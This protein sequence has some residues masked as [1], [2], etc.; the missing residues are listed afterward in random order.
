MLAPE[1]PLTFDLELAKEQTNENPVYYVQYGHARIASVFKNADASEIE[2]ARSAHLNRLTD[3]TEI[4][5]IRRLA[6]MPNIVQNV[7]ADL[8][9]HR[10]TRYARDIAGDFHQFYHACRILTEDRDERLARLA[11]CIATKTVLSRVLE[12]IGVSAPESM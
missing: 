4:A 2:A 1:S 6:D 10:L 11:L 7:V 8:A 12:L 9:P 5:L 3:A